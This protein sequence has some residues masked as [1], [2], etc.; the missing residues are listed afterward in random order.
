MTL[1]L[2]SRNA[3]AGRGEIASADRASARLAYID[4]MR[5]IAI[6]A[7]VAF[8]AHIP[9]FQGGFVGVDVFFVISGFLITQQIVRETLRGSFSAT[10]FYARRILRILPPLL[11]VVAVT[12]AVAPLFPLLPQEAH[13]LANSAAAT[14]VM[15]SN[16]YF[17]SGT[18]YFASKSEIVPLLHTWSLGVEEQYYL[19]APAFIAAVVAFAER[20][21]RRPLIALFVAGIFVI[22]GSYVVLAILT[23]TD[24]RLAFFSIMTRAWQ[25]SAGGMLAVAVIAGNEVPAK[26][27]NVL[28]LVGVAAIGIAVFGFNAQMTFPGLAAAAVPTLGTLLLLASGLG[29][30]RGPITRILASP[31]AVA[32]GLVSYSWYL[33]HWPLTALARALPMGQESLWKDVSASTLALVLAVV[34]YLAVERPMRRL[35]RHAITRAFGGRIVAAG[36]GASAIFAA[37]AFDLGQSPVYV[38]KA[39]AI[40]LG[41]PIKTIEGCRADAPAPK[42]QHVVPCLVGIEAPLKV[43]YWGDSHAL[44]L[45]P[46]AEWAAKAAGDAAIVLGKTSCPPLLGVEVDYFVTRTCAG[47]N[48]D[49]FAWLQKQP[50][51]TGAVLA[52]RWNLYNGNPTPAGDPDV[53]HLLWRERHE[54]SAGYADILA[55]TLTDTLKALSPRRVL[56]VGP[57]PELRHAAVDCLIRA[58]LGGQPDTTCTV[59]RAMVEKR[60]HEAMATIRQVAASFPNVRLIDPLDVFCD[61]ERCKP[62]GPDG[63]YYVDADHLSPLGTELL[64]RQFERDFNWVNG[65]N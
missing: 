32:I 59:D 37:V 40:A 23:K 33:W 54:G 13:E 39:P 47:S 9:G 1:D 55:R 8:H 6:I 46:I 35:R 50:S 44:M 21:K 3:A 26:F 29:N 11:L 38:P 17:S 61:A 53:P 22:A 16:Y 60:R 25:F 7:I 24:H 5:A 58:R 52:A 15:I 65:A 63:V 28:A 36:L 62:F 41:A 20:N 42:F 19:V 56:I 51:I 27:R 43:I 12:L 14:A 30:E 48:D 57:T 45:A 34:T 31:P 10:D 64:L 49:V 18:D 4:G 2:A